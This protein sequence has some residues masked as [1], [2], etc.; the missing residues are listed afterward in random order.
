MGKFYSDYDDLD[1]VVKQFE[2]DNYVKLYKK[3]SRTIEASKKRCPNR[4]F[5]PKVKYSE[6]SFACI[7]NGKYKPN[8]KT[9]ERP[10]HKTNR[11]GC[12]F[13]IKLRST[14]D[15]QHLMVT[16]FVDSHNHDISKEEF[17]MNP[18]NRK[19]D[20]DMQNEIH[21]IV[22]MNGNRKLIA[23]L[24]RKDREADL[25]EGHS[26]HCSQISSRQRFS[27]NFI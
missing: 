15:G 9:G 12:G 3:E 23:V 10:N 27:S 18:A 2:Q 4:K 17:Q 13:V 5:N 8:T 7:H 20:P 26:Q 16:S 21:S 6:V 25:N 22:K 19:L 24:L 11:I 1:K 14:A